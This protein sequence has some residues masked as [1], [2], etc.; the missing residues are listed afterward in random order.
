MQSINISPTAFNRNSGVITCTGVPG[1]DAD[2]DFLSVEYTWI[3]DGV[4][5]SN[6]Q[7]FASSA[8]SRGNVVTCSA[9]PYDGE[10]YGNALQT[11]PVTVA[12]APPTLAGIAL[13]NI[14]P[15]E[16][17]S[18]V[19]TG[20]T[21]SDPD[22]DLVTLTYQWF[23][24]GVVVSTANQIDSTLFNRGNTVFVR[25]TGT[26]SLGAT[27]SLDSQ[28]LTVV[29]AAPGQPAPATILPDI[30]YRTSTLT[31]SS[32]AT[33]PDGDAVTL[34]YTWFVNGVQVQSGV[35][36]SLAPGP[37]VRGQT[38][39]ATIVATDTFGL[40]G[41]GRN[42]AG[43]VIA[44][45][46]PPA[47][48]VTV[49]P[50][51][52][53]AGIDPLVCAITTTSTDPDGDAVTYDIRWRQGQVLVGNVARTPTSA[54][55]PGALTGAAEV[56]TCDARAWDGT[57]HGPYSVAVN[58]ST[59]TLGNE[60]CSEAQTLGGRRD[61]IYMLDGG[62]AYCDQRT[63]GGGWTRVIRT[64][65]D[66]LDVGQSS[67]DVV[68]NVV[69]VEALEG[70]YEAFDHVRGI[71]HVMIKA[72][73][74][75]QAGSWAA[76]ALWEDISGLSLREALEVCR[77]EPIWVADDAAFPWVATL[78]HTS[79]GSGR[80]FAGDL[81]LWDGG[82]VRPVD[83][84][85]LCGVGLQGFNGTGYLAFTADRLDR[86]APHWGGS[87]QAATLWSFAGGSYE[88]GGGHI[89]GAW[90]DTFAGWRG[91]DIAAAGHAGAYEVYV[92]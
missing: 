66:N 88:L 11:A 55:V 22:G 24:N 74:G 91:D 12:N 16:G 23:V 18:I 28:T 54:T 29:N 2:Q 71:Q 30:A 46:V 83:W 21:N 31:T 1:S 80:R 14:S 37:F 45:S 86:G 4:T 59:A 61:G 26:D 41:T 57:V 43:I 84:V 90:I 79:I 49:T 82:D 27:A 39:T 65:G 75:P 53:R 32:T 60:S 42:T 73:D 89:G 38:V 70:V 35:S 63:A 58:V 78:G 48:A 40:S 34:S 25:A 87:T 50:T 85:S 8:L 5:R 92:R 44:N 36:A 56:W 81:W 69:D 20:V 72:V 7:T 64:T 47:P 77:D 17:E 3:I 9:R 13:S 76:F 68:D 10:A 52:P 33:D 62:P 51:N 15:N 19:V 67:W 6:S